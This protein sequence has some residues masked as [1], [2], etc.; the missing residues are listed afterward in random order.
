MADNKKS[1]EE[2]DWY[3]AR[4]DNYKNWRAWG[5]WFSWGSPI[6]LGLFFVLLAFAAWIIAQIVK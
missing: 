3:Q 6:G 5:S 2:F 4:L 1:H